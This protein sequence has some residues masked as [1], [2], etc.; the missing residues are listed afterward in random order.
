VSII[1][2]L[3][4][5]VYIHH[6]VNLIVVCVP[7][8][9]YGILFIIQEN[10]S[11]ISIDTTPLGNTCKVI[12]FT[13]CYI[14][15]LLWFIAVLWN[16]VAWR[17]A[18]KR[19][20]QMTKEYINNNDNNGNLYAGISKPVFKFS[21]F[22]LDCFV[23]QDPLVFR[24]EWI[25][26][27]FSFLANFVYNAA[28]LADVKYGLKDGHPLEIVEVVFS[29]LYILFGII[30]FGGITCF[31]TTRHVYRSVTRLTFEMSPEEASPEQL[32]L[33]T[34]TMN[35]EQG[36]SLLKEYSIREFSLENVLLWKDL[37]EFSSHYD[38]LSLEARTEQA[39]KI[40][41][42]Y[43]EKWS[44]CKVKL[45]SKLK[46]KF[47]NLCIS[48]QQMTEEEAREVLNELYTAIII[49]ISDT[50]SRFYWT[51]T[52]RTYAGLRK[53]TSEER[54]KMIEQAVFSKQMHHENM[55]H[56]QE[57]DITAHH[58]YGINRKASIQQAVDISLQ[59]PIDLG[60]DSNLHL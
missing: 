32:E 3:I 34:K 29:S 41:Q 43:F 36:Y 49:N 56:I 4:T 58:R 10:I 15:G 9:V 6:M 20:R 59:E 35:D 53:Q 26:T 14:V 24:M 12:H 2:H 38:S 42:Q 46:V 19:R 8:I 16:T 11:R 7:F 37:M 18:V 48:L 23:E 55:E 60:L 57:E 5:S 52:Y 39:L 28:N 13:L 21:N 40:S 31:I 1:Y 22:L 50:W 54:L 47:S 51:E 17:R 25:A 45:S 27:A 44:P 33:I 30:A